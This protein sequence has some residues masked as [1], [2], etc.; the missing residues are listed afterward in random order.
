MPV[1]RPDEFILTDDRAIALSRLRAGGKQAHVIAGGTGFYELVKRGYVPEVKT[2]VS[3]MALGLSYVKDEGGHLHIGA[4]TTLQSLLESGVDSIPGLEAVS[5]ALKEVR[6]VQV[7]NVATVGGEVCIS[8]PIV[9]LPTALLACGASLKIMDQDMGFET[10][11]E[12]FYVDAFLTKLK[13]GELVEE[14]IL[15][16]RSDDSARSASAFSKF[17]RTAYDFNLVNCAV[18]LSLESLTDQRLKSVSLFI[19]GVKR[20]PIRAV[21]VERKLLGRVP[22]EEVIF[23]A[24]ETSFSKTNFLPSVHGS[25]DYKHALLPVIVRDC[26]MRAFERSLEDKHL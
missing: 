12:D 8:V 3:I 22:R 7:R 21:E 1:S 14:V 25:S 19:G 24:C 16:M 17:G 5:D 2:L 9:D 15:P 6:P 23:E 4:T 18:S 11:L 13:Y 10:K 20:T 26:V